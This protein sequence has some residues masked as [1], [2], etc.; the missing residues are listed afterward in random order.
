MKISN[1]EIIVVNG[2]LAENDAQCLVVPEF[3]SCASSG[4]VG[5]AIYRSGMEQ[6]MN[7]YDDHAQ[8]SPLKY[9]EVLLTRSGRTDT[10]LSH[11]ATAGAPADE[12]FEVVFKA[13]LNTLLQAHEL[14]VRTIAVPELC[15]GIIGNLT[16]AQSARAIF[17]AVQKFTEME[18][19]NDILSVSLVIFRNSTEPAK[20]VLS[21]GSYKTFSNERGQK[22]FDMA[23][24]LIGMGWIR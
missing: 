13:M 18:P 2:N 22:P 24:W 17:C 23:A 6:G 10:L 5:A 19:Q 15:T 1:I 8:N 16:Q 9:G 14:G 3:T 21:D 11:V 7:E 4:G 20:Q 12:Q